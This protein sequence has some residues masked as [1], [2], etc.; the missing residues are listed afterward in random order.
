MIFK[1]GRTQRGARA[2]LSHTG[3]F[4]GTYGR[5]QGAFRQAGLIAVDSME[6]LLAASKALA[7]QP[8]AA[9]QPRWP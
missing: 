9:R 1:V 6:E 4:G 7:L 8:E 3:F 2:S 5:G